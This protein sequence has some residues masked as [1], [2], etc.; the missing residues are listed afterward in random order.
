MA[1]NEVTPLP[2][3]DGDAQGEA[4]GVAAAGVAEGRGETV[5]KKVAVTAAPVAELQKLLKKVTDRP[6]FLSLPFF[7]GFWW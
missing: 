5:A 7:R 3:C 6:L 1:I 2:L 4:V